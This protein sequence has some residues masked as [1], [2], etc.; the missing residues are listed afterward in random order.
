MAS[1][2]T[3]HRL[4]GR[5]FLQQNPILPPKKRR[6]HF[7]PL[8]PRILLSADTLI[9][10]VAGALGDGLSEMAD[11][12]QE[13]LDNDPVDS[14]PSFADA[15]VPGIIWLDPTLDEAGAYV[16]PEVS[17]LIQ[18]DVADLDQDGHID[19][20]E[21]Q[22]PDATEP[23]SQN[24]PGNQPFPNPNFRIGTSGAV[25]P[26]GDLDVYDTDKDPLT[27]WKLVSGD[28]YYN[29]ITLWEP[30]VPSVEMSLSLMDLDGDTVVDWSEAFDVVVV[31][32]LLDWLDN[33]EAG[34]YPITDINTDFNELDGDGNLKTVDQ[35]LGEL[36]AFLTNGLESPAGLT[37]HGFQVNQ[38][39]LNDATP[40]IS[41]DIGSVTTHNSGPGIELTLNDV[42]I[43]FNHDVAIDLGY[44][45]DQLNIAVGSDKGT[46]GEV[47]VPGLDATEIQVEGGVYF[48]ELVV[49]LQGYAAAVDG[50]GDP[51]PNA[52]PTGATDIH[53]FYFTV[54]D[55]SLEI[56]VKADVDGIDT[57]V[58][59]GF[60]GT[61]TTTGEFLL[62]MDADSIFHDPSH[63]D[64]IG[65][66]QALPVTGTT[67]IVAGD[68]PEP[69][70][71]NLPADVIFTLKI[72]QQGT[73]LLSPDSSPWSQV[74]VDAL[75][76]ADNSNIDNLV[77]DINAALI[78]ASPFDLG[79]LITASKVDIGGG[80]YHIQFSLPPTNIAPLGFSNEEYAAAGTSL[81]AD[82]APTIIGNT[83]S[84]TFSFLLSVGGNL[85]K[86][87]EVTTTPVDHDGDNTTPQE[88]TL[89]QLIIDLNS[90]FD[91][92]SLQSE[93]LNN[94]F[95]VQARATGG[96]VEIFNLPNPILDPFDKSL[97]ITRTLTLDAKNVITYDEMHAATYDQLIS[98]ADGWNTEDRLEITLPLT[99]KT[100]LS[101]QDGDPYVPEATMKVGINPF[102]DVTMVESSVPGEESYRRPDFDLT[103]AGGFPLLDIRSGDATSTD[104][105]WAPMLD[106]TVINANSVIGGLSQFQSWLERLPNTELLANYQVPFAQAVLGNVLDFADVL[107]DALIIDDG[108]DGL[109]P[110]PGADDIAD[111][112]KLIG[113]LVD[114]DNA[115]LVITFDT[116]QEL[117]SRLDTLV[118]GDINPV[119]DT[120]T[121]ELTYDVRLAHDFEEV[122]VPAD[123]SINLDPLANLYTESTLYVGVAGELNA[124]LGFILGDAVAAIDAGTSLAEGPDGL[125]GGKGVPLSDLL[126]IT[127][128]K[129][130]ATYIGR[131]SADAV[132]DVSVA[133]AGAAVLARVTVPKV[134]T[135]SN[136]TLAQLLLDI[137]SA[138]N[139]AKEIVDGAV[140]DTTITLKTT[141]GITA[142]P[143]GDR[144]QLTT[145][146][147][148]VTG[149]N[150]TSA[151][152]NPSYTEL[153]LQPEQAVTVSLTSAVPTAVQLGE[154][155]SFSVTLH[156]GATSDTYN[157]DVLASDTVGNKTITDLVNDINTALGREAIG[158]GQ[159]LLDR[160]IAS[161]DGNQILFGAIDPEVNY[162]TMDADSTIPELGIDST[163]LAL[164]GT[165]DVPADGQ[166]TA[167]QQFILQVWF[168]DGTTLSE[169]GEIVTL[170]AGDTES[171]S[172]IADLVD[173][174]NNALNNDAG[175]Y[176][177]AAAEGNRIILQA[178]S[179]TVVDF[180]V[181]LISD[182]NDPPQYNSAAQLG[183][184]DTGNSVER[185][186][187]AAVSKIASVQLTGAEA[188]P[189]PYLGQ[190]TGPGNLGLSVTT[191]S[192]TTPYNIS[193]PQSATD[194]SAAG[195]DPNAD[196]RDLVADLN[197]ALIAQNLDDQIVADSDGLHMVLRAIDPSVLAFSVTS[198]DSE[199]G[200]LAGQG[201]DADLSILAN[202]A[203]PKYYGPGDVAT[204]TVSFTGGN[205]AGDIY[206][207]E[208]GT[209]D[210]A[211][212]R[213][214]Y[215]DNSSIYSLVSDMNRALSE[216]VLE[217]GDPD[218]KVD[219]RP[220]ITAS[221][222]G[223]RLVIMQSED[224]EIG[225]DYSGF[226]VAA[227]VPPSGDNPAATDLF[228]E[229]S[230]Q[231]DPAPTDLSVA[232]D[233]ADL[234]IY[235]RDGNLYRVSL[236]GATSMGDVA[237]AIYAQTS[238]KV[239]LE[240]DDSGTAINLRDAS[241][242]SALFRVDT[243]N[244]SG[245]AISLGIF[246]ADK[247]TIDETAD[248][249]IEG[250]Q[251]AA[252]ELADRVFLRGIAGEPLLGAEVTV[253]AIDDPDT[254]EYDAL[255]AKGAFG[256]VGVDLIGP[257]D[258]AADP[259]LLDVEDDPNTEDDE[260][261]QAVPAAIQETL[262]TG[263]F[264]SNLVT[265]G[266]TMTELFKALN[267]EEDVTKKIL[268]G[269]IDELAD[270]ISKPTFDGIAEFGMLATLDGEISGM[271]VPLDLGDGKL[272]IDLDNLGDAFAEPPAVSL[273]DPGSSYVLT[274]DF[275]FQ[276]AIDGGVTRKVTVLADNT[277][278]DNTD[279]A[280]GG[281]ATNTTLDHLI[282]DF[283]YALEQ[284][285]L[286]DYI[287]AAEGSLV[288]EGASAFSGIRF[289]ITPLAG[290]PS[291]SGTAG[292]ALMETVN[293]IDPGLPTVNVIDSLG[294]AF[295]TALGN[296]GDFQDISFDEV[297]QA[298]EG[299]V[300]FLNV[301]DSDFDFFTTEIPFLG[302][303][304]GDKLDFVNRLSAAVQDIKQ[305]PA[306]SL[307]ALAQKI[308]ENFGLPDFSKEP[309]LAAQT[310]AMEA[311]FEQFG[312]TDPATDILKLAFDTLNSDDILRLDLRL[313]V[314]FDEA[315]DVDLDLG[316][317]AGIDLGPLSLQGAA[318]LGATGYV[319][320]QLA[321]GINL[322]TGEIFLYEDDTSITG[323][324][325]AYSDT[326]TFNAALGPL[327]LFIQEGTARVDL[328]FDF[329]LVDGETGGWVAIGD[330]FDDF[331]LSGITSPTINA[332]LPLYFP[333]DSDY[334]GDIR[335]S[336]TVDLTGGDFNFGNLIPY[337]PDLSN[338]DFSN[339]SL[340]DNVGLTIDALDLFLEQVQNFMYGEVFGID[341]P[342]IG[343]SLAAGGD[344]L[345][346]IR[347]QVIQPFRDII[348]NAPEVA[349]ELV[350][351]FLFTILGPGGDVWT[352][353]DTYYDIF[354]ALPG[355][356]KLV[357]PT[358][359]TV[360]D[361]NTFNPDN[362]DDTTA[363]DYVTFTHDGEDT[364]EDWMDDQVQWDF[365]LG[366]R[367]TPDVDLSFDLGFPAL[368]LESDATLN[369]QLLWDLALGIGINRTDGAY[370]DIENEA[371]ALDIHQ[372]PEDDTD[373]IEISD[374]L[375]LRADAWFDPGDRLS[376]KLAFLQVDMFSLGDMN[377]PT[378][379]S[380][381]DA[382]QAYIDF[383]DRFK[384]DGD[385]QNFDQKYWD[386]NEQQLKDRSDN[387]GD[388]GVD[389]TR[390]T[391][392]FQVDLYND[393]DTEDEKDDHLSFSELGKLRVDVDLMAD[394][395][396]NLGL[397]AKFNEDIIPDSVAALIPQIGAQFVL[398]WSTGDLISA[399]DYEFSEML[400]LVEFRHVS[401]DMGSFL[402]D[403]LGPV[404][405][406][407]QE[408]TDP[409]Q[410]VI[411]VLTAR[412][413]VVSDLA[414]RDITLVDIAGLTGYVETG[415]IYAIADIVSL[416]NSIPAEPGSLMVPL[417][418]LSIF[419]EEFSAPELAFNLS[420]P[421]FDLG[422]DSSGDGGFSLG[423]A[424][425]GFQDS[426]DTL[427]DGIDTS[428]A[429]GA[430]SSS[431]ING[432]GPGAGSFGFPIFESP[433]E[434][435]GLLVG[436]PATLV[437]YDLPP[438]GMDFQW[439]QSFPVWG[440]F[441][442]V[443][444]IGAG[445]EVDL[446]FGYDTEG[447]SRFVEGD[448][449]NPLD[450]MAGF[451]ISDTDLPQG[452]GGT[453]VPELVLEG[454]VFAGA[455]LNL[456]IASAGVEGGLILTVNF[457]LYDPDRDGKVRVDEMLGAFLY[458]ART[459]NPA[460]APVAIF[461]V[462]GDISAQLRAYIKALFFEYQF[463]ITPK[464]VLFEFSIPF[465]RE[466]ILA[467]ERGDGA[468]LLNIGSNAGSRLN[469][470]TNDIGEEIHVTS[471]GGGQVEVWSSQLGVSQSAA[472]VYKASS[473]VAYGGQGDD[474]IYLDLGTSNISYNIEAG[475]G[476]D[477]VSVT[478]G[479]GSGL[480]RGGLG[481]DTLAGGG[482]ADIIYGEEGNDTID[483]GGGNDIVFG[484][485]GTVTYNSPTIKRLF[486][487]PDDTDGDDHLL[488]GLGEDLL[489]GGGGNDWL[490]GGED[491]DLLIG[492]GVSIT[493]EAGNLPANIWVKDATKARTSGYDRFGYTELRLT[494]TGVGGKDRLFGQGGDDV[495]YGGYGFDLLQGGA[496]SDRML[497]QTGMDILY[498]G[499]GSDL[500]LGGAHDDI[501]FGYADALATENAD[502]VVD[503]DA[504]S[505]DTIYG[506][507]GND[508][509][510]GQ[511]GEDFVYGDRGADIMFGDAGNDVM[512]GGINPDIIFGGADD[513]TI[514]GE[515][516]SDI[517]FG[518][519]GLVAFLGFYTTADA[520]SFVT[521]GILRD[522]GQ[523]GSLVRVDQAT[524]DRLIGD[525][526]AS[527][528]GTFT[529]D[530]LRE[531]KDL[532]V[533]E[534]DV[535]DGGD[536]DGA[537]GDDI[538]N[539]GAG[540]DVVFGGAGND[541]IGGDIAAAD[542]G[543]L[544]E[545]NPI[546]DD[547]LI[548]DGGRIELFSRLNRM[549]MSIPDA[550]SVGID[551]IFGDNGNDIA[552]GGISG[553]FIYGGH[554]S[555]RAPVLQVD[556]GYQDADVLLG[557][558][559]V[560]NLDFG[561]IRQ[562]YTSDVT[563]QDTPA[564]NTGGDDTIEGNEADDIIFGGV[565]GSP[566]I[567]YGN[568]GDDILLGDNGLIDFG[569]DP[570]ELTGVDDVSLELE[571][572]VTFYI[573]RYSD[574]T[575]V[576]V[577]VEAG[578]YADS[579][580]LAVAINAALAAAETS[581]AVPVGV[582]L[583]ADLLAV[584]AGNRLRIERQGGSTIQSFLLAAS[585][586]NP[587]GFAPTQTGPDFGTLELIVSEPYETDHSTDPYTINVNNILGGD[588]TISGNEGSDV[589]IGGVGGDTIYG[590]NA[591][592]AAAGDDGDD[593]LLGDNARIDL[594]G[595]VGQRIVF[596]TAVDYIVTTDT[597][598]L[599]GGADTMEG[600]AGFD[601]MLGG[602]NN[603]GIDTMYGDRSMPT[604][605]TIADDRDDILLGDNG[606]LD[607]TYNGDESGL[608][609]QT[610]D[611]IHS[612]MDGLGGTDTISGNRGLDVAIG[613]TAGDTIF[614]DDA[615]AS[616]GA[617]DLGDLLLGD[618]ADIFL[619]PRGDA[620]GG[621]IKLVL[622]MG[623]ATDAAVETIRTTDD[624]G[625]PEYGGSDT[626]S[627][628]ADGDIIAG[629]V[630][631]D[632]IYG[633]A[634]TVD[635]FDGDDTILGDNG[636]FEWL[637]NGRLNE[638]SGIDI[639]ENNPH[640]YG[641]YSQ[642]AFDTDLTTLDLMTTE[643]ATSGGRD[644]IYGDEGKDMI[645]GGTDSDTI[646]GDDG[647]LDEI[648]ESNNND[649]LFGDHGRLYPQFPRFKQMDGTF[650]IADYPARNFFAIDTGAMQG[651]EGDRMWGEEGDDTMVGQQGDDRMW[652]GSG[653]DDM[654]GGHNVAGGY[655]EIAGAI[656][657][658]LAGSGIAVPAID[659]VNDLMD[660][661]TSDDSMAGDNAIIW[662]RGDDFS[663]RFRELTEDSIYTT[664]P[665][666]ITANIGLTWQSDPDDA[667]GRD[668]ELVDHSDA[669]ESD[670]QGR[671]GADV[672]AGGADSDVMFGELA[673]DLMQGDGLIASSAATAPFLNYQIDVDDTGSNPDTDDTLYFNIPELAS[674][675]DDYM[676]G[677]GGD[678]LMYGGLGQDDM[679]G[680]SSELFGLV[681]E[682][683]RP[684]GS[685]VMYG[686]AGIAITR[687]DIGATTF[688]L[689]SEDPESHVITTE[690]DG[691]GRDADFIM[692]DNANIYRL[693]DN[694]DNFL[695]F[696]YDDAYGL[697]IIPRAMEQ[698][699]YQL[700]G[701]DYNGGE[702]VN[703]A[704]DPD[705]TTGPAPA[706]NGAADLIHGESGDDIIFGMTGSDLLFGE[707]QD[708]D[709]I[710]GY[711]HDWISGGTGQDGI[712][713][714]DGLIYTSRNS[715]A[716]EPL[717]SVEGLLD[718][719]PSTK[720]NNGNVLD[721]IISTPGDIQYAVINIS[722]QLKK[723][724]DLVPFSF[725]PG[726]IASDDEFPDNQDAFPYA[727]DIIFGGL[728]SDWLHGGSGDDA[729]SGAEALEHA[730][731]PTYD[732]DGNPDG[733]L[734]LG[735][736]A[737]A[738]PSPVNPGN[739]LAF[740]PVDVDGRH[741]NNRFRAGEFALYNEYDPL[742]K[743]LLNDD[744]SLWDPETQLTPPTK[745]FLLNFNEEEGV[746]RPEGE[747][748][749][750]TGQ[751]TP[752]YP[753][754][755][756]DG[757]DAIFGD[758]GNDWLVGGTGRDNMYGGWGNDLLNADDNQTTLGADGVTENANDLP[759]THPTYEDRAY[760]GAGRDVLIANT[761]G[762]RL[763]DWVGEYNSYLVPYAP[764]GQA[765]VSRT[766]M[767]HLH[768]FL[769]SLSA[770]DGADPTRY[771]DAI[772]G[773]EPL[774]TNNDPIPSR[775][776]EP[777]GELGL[778]LQKDFAWGDQTGAPAD[779]QAGN[780]PGGKRDVLRTAGFNDYDTQIA[781]TA[782]GVFEIENNVLKVTAD[783]LGGDAVSVLALDEYLPS[784]FE[785]AATISMEKPTG[786]WKANSYIIFDYQ[787]ETNFKFAGID[788]S[789]DKIELGHRTEDGWIIDAE[790]PSK[791]KPGKYYN[792]LVAV[793]GTN[794]TVRL[795]GTEYFSHTYEAR[796]DNDGWVYGINEGM[797]GLGS[798]NSRGLFDN[799]VVQV[800][801]PEYTYQV[802]EDFADAELEVP[803]VSAD[804]IWQI[805]DS[806][807]RYDGIP[808]GD[809]SISLLDLGIG[810]RP[811]SILDL[812][813]VVNTE[814][815]AGFI[816]DYYDQD[817]FKYVGLSI[818][819]DTLL[820]GHYRAGKWTVE[821]T[822]EVSLSADADYELALSLKGTTVD[823]SVKEAGTENWLAQ[824][825]YI[826]NGVTVDG[827]FGLLASGGSASFDEV[828]FKTNDPAF[829]TEEPAA[830][831]ASEPA[832]VIDEPTTVMAADL[833]PIVAEA[834]DRWET[835]LDLDD[836]ALNY[837]LDDVTFSITDLGG[838][839]LAETVGNTIRIDDDAAGY[840][841]FIDT[842]PEDS[843]EFLRQGGIGY[844]NGHDTWLATGVSPALDQ[845]D[846]LTV[847]THEIGHLLGYD[848]DSSLAVMAEDLDA[849]T[850]SVPQV[851]EDAA[852]PGK[853]VTMKVTETMVFDEAQG[854]FHNLLQGT[855]GDRANGRSAARVLSTITDRAQE[856]DPFWLVEV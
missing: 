376:G 63:P 88:V 539:G 782:S 609:R 493:Y 412:I 725:D 587:L 723:T 32:Q 80:E 695:D 56:G 23:L 751:Q 754:V 698:L 75:S 439:R 123:F 47:P 668:I 137:D 41:V 350:Q 243:V 743:I 414:G 118:A 227:P 595:T 509:I 853:T 72:G 168:A 483:G 108:D 843:V 610:L 438:F 848:H 325:K 758:L 436:R 273:G 602:V 99:V 491:R 693:V 309:D 281:G 449:S 184:P 393:D 232:A 715:T 418:N 755:N 334:L 699:D 642:S 103:D 769:Y 641:K 499:G 84:Q 518:D 554:G 13:F 765:S 487:L 434:V 603:G 83:E 352:S 474:Q 116:A 202:K 381:D 849:G 52:T 837:M 358:D 268:P 231:L 82:T 484:D 134:D 537:D 775:N 302:F 336:P 197:N 406:K 811:N 680:G 597:E 60:L 461:D 279:A 726:W 611:Y 817:D 547:V 105:D 828:T 784:Y 79:D 196:I 384:V 721:E 604:S 46:S 705:G 143:E 759:D 218:T 568:T 620:S 66:D 171:N 656:V 768:E 646:Y 575:P 249:L 207:V 446:A 598:E 463:D 829:K 2:W 802:S 308:R 38:Q 102:T 395:E 274:E 570:V 154:D 548:G 702:Y 839:L 833:D 58:N 687:N 663:P 593:I 291:W 30:Y 267:A 172:S 365:R 220:Y 740:N 816:F 786:G 12:V 297:I 266:L 276:V 789:R 676:E 132:F 571:E 360:I 592:A 557:D 288:L 667:V 262:Y 148:E 624:E 728:G 559:G 230:P 727:D 459:G 511:D 476:D 534:V 292:L 76:T 255:T 838:T 469:G 149:F 632:T 498:G 153:G 95:G 39:L 779:P 298:L 700:G 460:L 357:E 327:G 193:I 303:S 388:P 488:G 114:G 431:V 341:L 366:D 762:D 520:A 369:L 107:E 454:E 736:D 451:F 830:L 729:I 467:T 198:G 576:K 776:G 841:W 213:A 260:S 494:D 304:L 515:A 718:R 59:V 246:G 504:D 111:T 239:T 662:R 685:D 669:I 37:D 370:I 15:E 263:T 301:F 473:I 538:I 228:L 68:V 306:G 631:G 326:L 11:N 558:N 530:G 206:T 827:S 512:Q 746:V 489:I 807:H 397:V 560:I 212:G 591:G 34:S 506:E 707:G 144:I 1:K 10:G 400:E 650:V 477:L 422:S 577:T 788:A 247:T 825:G 20:P 27:V 125:N 423:G 846:L 584:A 450:L 580:A 605:A 638:I 200:I 73:S 296:L 403:F 139:N 81:I 836:G 374:E 299:L 387:G 640:L 733:V 544:P 552:F 588:D 809:F 142:E 737:V 259:W 522:A 51:L 635:D 315:I 14:D 528:I 362:V 645:F 293:S 62:E 748:P 674:D 67:S 694:E 394:A 347:S 189:I 831:N 321:F 810:L 633:D 420:L 176:V 392:V 194:G 780:I 503:I 237:D 462:Y 49:G 405:G 159:T 5:N 300:D 724:A 136:E 317:L 647:T 485:S 126:A 847:L 338:I 675:A 636:A 156:E 285:K 806:T 248:G 497:G 717:N 85:P 513:D 9:P 254:L 261:L 127:G 556:D 510:R 801:P 295:D 371:R 643:Q 361:W 681:E 94:T 564:T 738:L 333:T 117:A 712:L 368:G 100:G 36:D 7:E 792:V 742:H 540:N 242:G 121:S 417:G 502:T 840:G 444:T 501:M 364:A 500:M 654:T 569:L 432:T 289:D 185:S 766:M 28:Y 275:S 272:I 223:N 344:F 709:I 457:D 683:M 480:I 101:N 549:I 378:G 78:A 739:V 178:A 760:G 673:N 138:L 796:V 708:D 600:N 470:N 252:I 222:D 280:T 677:N 607:F 221:N 800:L 167:D 657:A 616:A 294:A 421:D 629:G 328:G 179:K 799:L 104:P 730:W 109:Q 409:L 551:H 854:V 390:L 561:I 64:A 135:D 710:G 337:V 199:L 567:L 65:F 791:I 372:T 720:Y 819:D 672:M 411:D 282:A 233:S 756:D 795:D 732:Q 174:L 583:S 599:T 541:W 658:D 351:N 523:L 373:D 524:G 343:D 653:D 208:V 240:Y 145:A 133:T 585:V 45:S 617:D 234:L 33:S 850:R 621:D 55:G 211:T 517:I 258:P 353:G 320:A 690:I 490:E 711:G 236:D 330:A 346:N 359:G 832:Q 169:F 453:D 456:G 382:V 124:T 402:G 735:Y 803:F 324:L 481:N 741:L 61:H 608:D 492:D 682:E 774:P 565:N 516:G 628:N 835:F 455:E 590:D 314:G 845:M 40:Y 815:S 823:V 215:L 744:G 331:E 686:G 425:G 287:V 181:F 26:E 856:E 307:Q 224:A 415:M 250:Q 48:D 472:Q 430:T 651:G 787:D 106:F 601:I 466:P 216:A 805:N 180:G 312:I 264:A 697:Q 545:I 536:G 53:D 214:D 648:T 812:E 6:P 340:F 719:D 639:S 750:A 818:T 91:A 797:I 363:A 586:D 323:S 265:D 122:P 74:V 147:L 441:F 345:E 808:L 226:S 305:N 433:S 31:G 671:F 627:G 505:G 16:T 813:T 543:E 670:P 714:D 141:Y 70:D 342:F 496:G 596:G 277:D 408:I 97:E 665:D 546:G 190:L 574:T 407:I 644:T 151:A 290:L 579:A 92:A 535:D 241:A 553:D 188:I 245:A 155:A 634:A 251:I 383:I 339:L 329:D 332:T 578:T 278:G 572:A 529:H 747:V 204:F 798:N 183:F 157:V 235:T 391:A 203:A 703:D 93:I 533:T 794:V 210:P 773:E 413:P 666:T 804:G 270:V 319:D 625:H 821:A 615:G 475:S 429:T 316:Q 131:L 257:F 691:H 778:V 623:L 507:D 448:F 130:V 44:Q 348:A 793:N 790:T 424:L 356:G 29:H 443:L 649:L 655:D 175:N 514:D 77:A 398:D 445:V 163:W 589:A 322:D 764:F 525:G 410:P 426:L 158:G 90:S 25:I 479:T 452:T 416:V 310:A 521:D 713:G 626:I 152:T 375:Y 219:L 160:F 688:D 380:S 419:S 519:D 664:R 256:F 86:L 284:A 753:E 399:E 89:N 716:G 550:D 689:A 428:G 767:P 757:K 161:R 24:F 734:D 8:E 696:N 69:A 367:Y 781:Y 701:A 731:V 542:S 335:F 692:G 98:T 17:D 555:G 42:K 447:V 458:E 468:L 442:V 217:G 722:G 229:P 377:P 238:N 637:S 115:N 745:E 286:S 182:A 771:S 427:L 162:F 679:V 43:V 508:Y 606:W 562:V 177:L 826:Y 225:T 209:T 71:F 354:N 57:D 166:L 435:F 820:I 814:A 594:F 113:W 486:G 19:N 573:T 385:W 21:E 146:D 852:A 706:D 87:I 112:N 269:T 311:Y 763:I 464:I 186:Y 191:T 96:N 22:N 165:Q 844:G 140:T 440:P 471:L 660:G 3:T 404:V 244:R 401:I 4:F 187:S 495:M 613:G 824:L 195:T 120:A 173:D 205:L 630:Y 119:F 772:G 563:D 770:G 110:N 170:N 128:I 785:V 822:T 582:N 749:K 437:T 752:F 761:G 192:A 684:D 581:E 527:L 855:L 614:G 50:D 386:P 54:P 379:T 465:D 164:Q 129:D 271:A 349:G 851:T 313:P 318:G 659:A 389:D 355:L 35:F 253:K 842:T 777:H 661:G 619:V 532:I 201:A 618:N 652:G 482:G 526:A 531:T 566:D 622:S 283:N 834:V 150:I 18:V 612:E 678:D 704:A 396:V 783:S 478:G